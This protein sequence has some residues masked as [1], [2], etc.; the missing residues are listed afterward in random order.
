[1]AAGP[2][3]PVPLTGPRWLGVKV[4]SMSVADNALF[5]NTRAPFASYLEL[6][7]G[8]DLQNLSI[9]IS[10]KVGKRWDT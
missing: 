10:R 5:C 4:V 8:L 9:Q 6:K 2:T 1:M 7:D 3:N